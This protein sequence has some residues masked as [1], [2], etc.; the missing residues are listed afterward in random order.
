MIQN[1]EIEE[2]L[3]MNSVF[4]VRSV[5][6]LFDWLKLP[7]AK[8]IKDPDTPMASVLHR[9]IIQKKQFLKRVYISFYN[10]FKK[11]VEPFN[12]KN[13]IEL[14][15]GGGFIKEIMPNVRT[16]DIIKV[17]GVDMH[18]S[19]TKMPFA[20]KS[21][22]A[23]FMINVLHHI[24]KPEALF[25]ELIRCLKNDGKIVMIEPANTL[26]GRFIFKNFH[27]ESFNSWAGWNGKKNM[28]LSYGNI[29]LPWIIFIRDRK[30]F[31]NKFPGLKIVKIKAHTPL[32]YLL[33][34]GLL[35]KQLVPSWSYPLVQ[36]LETLLTPFNNVI[37]M[38]YTIELQ[39][40]SMHE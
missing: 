8:K 19:A 4:K 30:I 21:V 1:L 33:S 14:G 10:Q 18:F 16:S 38:F 15:S 20:K 27:H 25:K 35:L 12:N 31:K 11:S 3:K 34:G 39:K 37:G 9:R 17:P 6:K 7:E 40:V 36:N 24:E 28:P 32:R 23:F 13:L 29:A 22:D 2:G 5:M 26:L